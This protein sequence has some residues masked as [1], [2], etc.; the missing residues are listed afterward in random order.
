MKIN[1]LILALSVVCSMLF[2][3][4]KSDTRK[5]LK[6]K[7]ESQKEK[8]IFPFSEASRIEV[9]SYKS[10]FDTDKPFSQLLTDNLNNPKKLKE[11]FKSSKLNI[12][13]RITLSADQTTTLFGILYKENCG[14]EIV[15]NCFSPRHALIFYNDKD[16]PIGISEI[17]LE[18]VSVSFSKDFTKY[19]LCESKNIKIKQFLKDIGI[20]YFEEPIL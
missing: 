14:D 6:E 7:V 9:F 12:K 13:E 5:T 3:A 16:E 1:H 8:S 10:N 17:D 20:T 18:C 2:A 4:C 19:K 15:G 11:V